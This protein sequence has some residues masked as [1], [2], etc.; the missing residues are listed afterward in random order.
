MK[1]DHDLI[2][3]NDGVKK[4]RAGRKPFFAG[5]G[6]IWLTVAVAALALLALL[7]SVFWQQRPAVSAAVPPAAPPLPTPTSLPQ[8]TPTP[9]TREMG[10]ALDT[11]YI[12]IAPRDFAQLEAR[13]AEALERW[14]LLTGDEDLV[15]A[16]VRLGEQTL[17]VRLR[18]KG[19]WAEHVATD[20]W[21]LRIETRN[22]TYLYGMQV[23]SIQDPSMR[24]FLY[25][26]A[27]LEALRMEDVLGVGYD[28]VRVVL[29]GEPKGIYALE[30][31]F[32]KELLESQGRREGVIIR[33]AE[34]L[35]W[36]SRAFYDEQVIPPGVEKFHIIDDFES[37]R[38]DASPTLSA[39]RDTAVGLL[40]GFLEGQL[41][42]SE[43]FEVDQMGRFLALADLWSAPHGLIWHNL[44]YYYN[45]V[46]ARLEPI[47][48]D[49]DP[50]SPELDLEQ[51]G[52]PEDNFYG[53]PQLQAAYVKALAEYSQPGYVEALEA[54]LGPRYET[55]RA[56]LEPEFGADV[57]TPPWDRL[58][59]RQEL[60]R[61]RL[62]P[63]Q[64]TYAYCVDPADLSAAVAPT[65]TLSIEVG[66]LMDLPVEIVSVSVAGVELPATREWVSPE[67]R[68]LTAT[69]LESAPEALV[70]RALPA[71]TASLPYVRLRLPVTTTLTEGLVLR[72]RLWGLTETLTQTVLPAYVLPLSDSP[73]PSWPTL[74]EALARHPYLQPVPGE[75]LLT[76]P[77]GTWDISGT[78]GLPA[79]YGLRLGPG[80][81][82]RFGPEDSLLS[83]GP[84]VFEGTAEAPVTLQ[85][86]DEVWR[87]IA[88]MRAG[89]PSLWTYTI[90]EDTDAI[91]RDGW[92]T[93]GGITFYRS[94]VRISH[95]R[96]LGTRA[97]DG[98]NVIHAPFEITDT[99][100]AA[101]A[102]DAFDADFSD[103]AFERCVFH[104][105]GADGIDVSGSEVTVREVHFQNLGDKG[106]SVGERSVM[107]AEDISV[108]GADF[109]FA[110][111]DRSHL[112]VSRATLNHIAIAGLAA[113]IKK[114]AYGPATMTVTAIDFGNVPAERQALVQSRSWIDLDGERIWGTD[115]DVEAL[116]EKWA[117]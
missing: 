20:K 41:P 8:P 106:L 37:G 9:T 71:Q 69:P 99:E 76:I 110:S 78:L 75:P 82:L 25:E 114:P 83:E 95:S 63:L 98:L 46:T 84:L 28:F 62:A 19:D 45:P 50:F 112:T 22:D 104:D 48:F 14:I 67:T 77:A 5:R 18:L 1:I 111:K 54:Q 52:L 55:L 66:N 93:T 91:A 117:K 43:V 72:T 59:R 100:F 6:F 96:I 34:D 31:G 27:Y 116:Y 79:G 47:A 26:D 64:L 13:R 85:P 39:Q 30:E 80:T 38:V 70:L 29:N 87:G 89:A 57:L 51:V 103:G 109:G 92:M 101:T 4:R 10:D 17:P 97:E 115:V 74:E 12:E 88:V 42:A 58:R 23:F 113:Y 56:A 73:R 3:G 36:T 35:L 7:L 60:I 15:P 2:S 16:T 11:L 90:I 108:D 49:N 107:T 24:T 40:R 65:D 94:P 33:Y 102:S 44:R 21:S 81:T 53:D 86:R 105:I 61:E 68:E 32:A